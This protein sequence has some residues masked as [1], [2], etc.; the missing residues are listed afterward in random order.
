MAFE[1]RTWSPI[2]STNRIV[3]Q[4]TPPPFGLRQPIFLNHARSAAYSHLA[5]SPQFK[6]EP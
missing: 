3:A 6:R 2:C 1:T 5:Q 4:F